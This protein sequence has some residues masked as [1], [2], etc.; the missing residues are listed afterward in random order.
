MDAHIK[1]EQYENLLKSI[2][3]LIEDE[4]DEIAI[5]ATVVCELHTTME[6]FHWTGFYRCVKPG[7]L[8]VGPYQGTHGCLTIPFEKGVC[9]KAAKEKTTQLVDDVTSIPFH[10]ACSSTTR[11]EIVV[12]LIDKNGAVRAVLDVD[13]N[14]SAA[15]DYIDKKYLEEIA[16]MIMKVMADTSVFPDS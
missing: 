2:S 13:S 3:A 7:L 10:I 9:G 11:S 6:Y 15:F 1:I 5:L 8:K 16:D 12:P 4:Q 14:N